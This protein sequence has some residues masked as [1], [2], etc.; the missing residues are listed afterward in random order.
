MYSRDE[1]CMYVYMYVLFNVCGICYLNIG[2]A[3]LCWLGSD[4]LF[5]CRDAFTTWLKRTVMGMYPSEN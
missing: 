1:A 3:K 4:Y 5:A 2:R